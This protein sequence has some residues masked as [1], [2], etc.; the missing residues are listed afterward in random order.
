M[1]VLTW[2]S[3]CLPTHIGPETRDR[4]AQCFRRC[5][6]NCHHL[7]LETLNHLAFWLHVKNKGP[8]RPGLCL[9]RVE[10]EVSRSRAV[11]SPPHCAETLQFSELVCISCL[12]R[13][14]PGVCSLV[15]VHQPHTK[16]EEAVPGSPAAG[17]Q[18]SSVYRFKE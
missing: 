2:N 5:L 17:I 3:C 14:Q 4:A 11:D 10:A 9:R 13:V 1:S 6:V 12:G 16:C 15:L 7:K 8:L 18:F